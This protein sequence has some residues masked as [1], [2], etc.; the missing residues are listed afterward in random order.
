MAVT[1]N[2]TILNVD[3]DVDKRGPSCI[4][5]ESTKWYKTTVE[6]VGQFPKQLSINLTRQCSNSTPGNLSKI[7]KD[8]HSH[9]DE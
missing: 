7:N 4:G 6:N 1:L 3:K 2:Q 9:K 5:G 8:T